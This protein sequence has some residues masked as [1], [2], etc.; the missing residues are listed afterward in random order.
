MAL[1]MTRRRKHANGTPLSDLIAH[2]GPAFECLRANVMIA[3][4]DLT[5]VYANTAALTTLR[6]VESQVR[7]AFGIGVDE[8]IGGS[9]HRMHRDPRRVESIL[10]QEG[11]HRLPHDA[12]MNFGSVWLRTHINAL[13]DAHGLHVGYIVA[14]EEVSGIRRAERVIDDLRAHLESAATAVEEMSAAIALIADNAASAATIASEAVAIVGATN[15]TMAALG[16]ESASIN[17]E[18]GAINS[19]ADRTKLLALNATI[20]AARAGD[21]GKGFVVVAEE[22]KSLADTTAKVTDSISARILTVADQITEVSGSMGAISEVI[23]RI[24]EHQTSIASAVEEQSVVTG[25]IAQRIASA[26]LDSQHIT[27]G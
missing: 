5:L 10:H 19:V 11:D 1:T 8:L 26:V 14:W 17:G 2:A 7:E 20:E 3:D 27:L 15:T 24:N 21:A 9:I 25:E 4:L 6:T 22:V 23:D 16:T 12:E 13:R 18:V